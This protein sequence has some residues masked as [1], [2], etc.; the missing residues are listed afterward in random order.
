MLTVD[1]NLFYIRKFYVKQGH[2][3]LP[4]I[5][6]IDKTHTDNKG[7]LCQEA[8]WF[9][10]GLFNY[11][12]RR[13]PRAWGSMGYLPN[14]T[15]LPNYKDTTLSDYHFMLHE[16]FSEFIDFQHKGPFNWIFYFKNE[17]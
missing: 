7:H 16:I 4:I 15:L 9:T 14:S 12:I 10:H 17:W 6:F 13:H 8:I 1:R 3:I 5:M 2:M 11:S